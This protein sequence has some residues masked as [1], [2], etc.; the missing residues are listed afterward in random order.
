MTFPTHT[1]DS[2]PVDAQAAMAATTEKFGA[3][4]PAVARLATSP[5]LLN[6]FLTASAAFEETTLSPAAREIVIMTV[7]VRH[8]CRICVTIHSSKLTALGRA[9]LIDPLTTSTS[10]DDPELEAVRTFTH[11]LLDS[12]GAVDQEQLDCFL[13]AGHTPQQALDIVL[14]IGTYTMSTIANRLVGA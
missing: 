1:I 10:L 2:A 8:G 7:A 12:T 4:P 5:Q 14:G 6:E 13:G 3:M 9:D 11:Q